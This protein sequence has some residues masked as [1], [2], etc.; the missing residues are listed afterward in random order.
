MRGG[1]AIESDL[2]ALLWGAIMWTVMLTYL[3]F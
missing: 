3:L 2:V 1:I